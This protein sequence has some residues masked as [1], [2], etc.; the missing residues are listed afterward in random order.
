MQQ[1][2]VLSPGEARTTLYRM[3]SGLTSVTIEN[4]LTHSRLISLPL[5]DALAYAL[6]FNSPDPTRITLT[7]EITPDPLE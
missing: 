7:L 1:A 6:A 5:L 2:L 4:Q 3:P